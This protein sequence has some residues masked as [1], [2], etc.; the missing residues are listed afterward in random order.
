MHLLIRNIGS[1]L[2]LVISII[3]DLGY[4]VETISNKP[5]E[6]FGSILAPFA[7]EFNSVL[8][9]DLGARINFFYQNICDLLAT[10]YRPCGLNPE[11]TQRF[12]IEA[13]EQNKRAIIPLIQREALISRDE[14]LEM[15]FRMAAVDKKPFGL[16]RNT[17]I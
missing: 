12:Y 4:P 13:E 14:A 7:I 8:Q 5:Q 11:E 15:D 3:H 17:C 9:T 6:V 1:L 16:E 10:T 2:G